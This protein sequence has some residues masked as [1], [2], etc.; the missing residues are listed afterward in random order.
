MYLAFKSYKWEIYREHNEH[1]YIYDQH[2]NMGL[3]WKHRTN[4]QWSIC[5]NNIPYVSWFKPND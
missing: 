5:I 3:K 1:V 4:H 2:I